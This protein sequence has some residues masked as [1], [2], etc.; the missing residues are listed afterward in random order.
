MPA[1]REASKRSSTRAIAA[2]RLW[3]SAAFMLMKMASDPAA[4]MACLISVT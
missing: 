1:A 3:S 4:L 2:A